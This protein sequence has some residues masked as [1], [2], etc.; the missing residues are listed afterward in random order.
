VVTGF[1][2]FLVY[3]LQHPFSGDISITP[4]PFVKC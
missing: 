2:L 3:A 4:E 1:V